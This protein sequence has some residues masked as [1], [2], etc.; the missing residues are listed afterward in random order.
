MIYDDIMAERVG[1][2]KAFYFI[3]LCQYLSLLIT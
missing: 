2:Q 3:I 1:G